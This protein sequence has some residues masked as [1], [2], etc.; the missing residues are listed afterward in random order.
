[1]DDGLLVPPNADGM[2]CF[3]GTGDN[4]ILVR[5]HEIGHVPELSTFFKNNPYG[6]N[7]K[8][9]IKNNSSKFYDIKNNNTHCFGGT[10]SIVYN[11]KTKTPIF[12][13]SFFNR[14]SIFIKTTFKHMYL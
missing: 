7:F 12:I 6:D 4:V 3:K 11:T 2:M 10:T 14:S 1:M 8:E 5:N 9:Y 13:D